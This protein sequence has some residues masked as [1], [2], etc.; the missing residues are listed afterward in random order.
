MVTLQSRRVEVDL[1]RNLLAPSNGRA[2]VR[3]LLSNDVPSSF[4]SDALLATSELVSNALEHGHGALEV[5]ARFY[6]EPCLLRV[7]VSDSS[8]DV[9]QPREQRPS[10][11]GGRGL[12]LVAAVS[13]D[14][15][16][17]PNERGKTVWFEL[18]S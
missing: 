18:T 3:S 17:T 16:W 4:M 6:L 14:W 8:S 5:L 10:C 13:T 7:E 1:A 2:V 9:P 11:L 12:H 15:G